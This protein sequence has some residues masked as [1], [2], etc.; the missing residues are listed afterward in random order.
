MRIGEAEAVVAVV[1]PCLD[2]E[3][4]IGGLIEA[5]RAQ[6]VDEVIAV[7]GGSRDRTVERAKAAGAEVVVERAAATAAPA[8]RG[9]PPRAP[10]PPSSPSW[11]A[12]APMTPPSPP[13]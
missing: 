1:I 5:L 13:P 8:R 6:G 4:A 7:D 10:T 9:W 3:A 11:T 2:E 12:T